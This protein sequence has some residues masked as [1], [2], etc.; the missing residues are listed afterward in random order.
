MGLAEWI[1]VD[2][3]LVKSAFNYILFFNRENNTVGLN[4]VPDSA[5]FAGEPQDGNQIIEGDAKVVS[6][7]GDMFLFF[8]NEYYFFDMR[9]EALFSHFFNNPRTVF[10]SR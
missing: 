3:H 4:L 7:S 6:V 8:F 5:R 1:V 2:S 9:K 10:I